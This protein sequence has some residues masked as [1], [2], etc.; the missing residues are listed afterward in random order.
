MESL[1]EKLITINKE[2]KLIQTIAD[3]EFLFL[4][5]II[6]GSL[7]LEQQIDN[8]LKWAYNN[9]DFEDFFGEHIDSLYQSDILTLIAECSESF[10]MSDQ[11]YYLYQFES[12]NKF[13]YFVEAFGD[14]AH[15]E[16]AMFSVAKNNH[17]VNSIISDFENEFYDK[18]CLYGEFSLEE[19]EGKGVTIEINTYLDT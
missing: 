12:K 19:L 10:E 6:D 13:F 11:S 18:I 17:D 9:D 4:D 7:S 3:V 1:V 2:F 16:E 8:S 5:Y 15:W 14:V